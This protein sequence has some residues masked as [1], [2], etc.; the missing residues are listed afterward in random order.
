MISEDFFFAIFKI[1]IIKLAISRPR[2]PRSSL[3]AALL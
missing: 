2:L 3:V 1:K